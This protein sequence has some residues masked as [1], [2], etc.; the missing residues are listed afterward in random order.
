MNLILN[1]WGN[2]MKAPFEKSRQGV[3]SKR[4]LSFDYL[5]SLNKRSKR[6]VESYKPWFPLRLYTFLLVHLQQ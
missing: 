6:M 3:I 5:S 4:L 2:L 1:D